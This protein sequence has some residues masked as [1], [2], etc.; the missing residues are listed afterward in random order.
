VKLELL[1]FAQLLPRQWK[2][3]GRNQA[4][5]VMNPDRDSSSSM[6]RRG[7]LHGAA[8]V[9]GATALALASVEAAEPEYQP[10]GRI[11]HSI[12]RWCFNDHYDVQQ[13]C[14]VAKQ[15]GCKSVEIV[16]PKE[17]GILKA[18]QLTCAIAGS[19]SFTQGMNHPKYQPGCLE[20]LRKTIDLCADAG[21]TTVITFTGYAEEMGEWAGGKM[22]D[23]SKLPAKRRR[24]EPDEG[25]KNCVAGFKQIV[26][27]AEQKKV[28][29][30]LEML[31]SRVSSHPMKGHPGYQGDHI[32]Y[33]ME[34]IRQVGSPRFGLLFDVYHV[35]IMD[36]DIITRIHQCKD[37]IN[38]VHTAGNPG[39]GELD[40]EQ[41]INYSAV[42]KALLEI[43]YR[44]YVGH[45]FIP[46]RAPLEGLRQA[47][48]VCDV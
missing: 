39:R 28:N 24:V 3:L 4:E 31:N 33:C 16:D 22:P 32:D 42:M 43:G 15:L 14:Q 6:S 12:V 17:W 5:V 20:V 46:T 2:M 34:I 26:G 21:F 27:Y 44:G 10:K 47:V 18:H 40:D 1:K 48:Q 11:Q 36:G 19:H 38:H 7:W 37:A 23:L 8:A 25:S 41:E 30:S 9:G 45:E 35:Q 29:L 13:L